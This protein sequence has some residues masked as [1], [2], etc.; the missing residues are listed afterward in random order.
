MNTSPS[1]GKRR[2][3]SGFIKPEFYA[4]DKAYKGDVCEKTTGY[5]LAEYAD[6]VEKM[7]TQGDYR[8]FY[9]HFY[10]ADSNKELKFKTEGSDDEY[11]I[12]KKE[13]IEKE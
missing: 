5:T 7:I 2:G 4:K 10:Y 3:S 11:I 13:F 12:K 6:N 8:L 1:T 9:K